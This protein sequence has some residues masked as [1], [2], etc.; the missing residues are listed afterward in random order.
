MEEIQEVRGEESEEAKAFGRI[1][2]AVGCRQLGGMK[3]C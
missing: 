3:V 1:P 2:F